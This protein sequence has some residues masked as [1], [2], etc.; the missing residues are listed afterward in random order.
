MTAHTTIV[1]ALV[2]QLTTA[3]IN[4]HN[5][6]LYKIPDDEYPAV[7]VTALS[8]TVDYTQSSGSSGFYKQLRVLEIEVLVKA[9]GADGEAVA[10]S[11]STV[12][13]DIE[14]SVYDNRSLGLSLIDNRF[15][16]TTYEYDNDSESPRGSA[17]L[18]FTVQYQISEPFSGVIV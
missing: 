14:D 7:F 9:I 8:E 13:T 10:A 12:V 1:S 17:T 6:R 11:L 18:T 3:G 5:T 16:G 4:A 15:D 2:E